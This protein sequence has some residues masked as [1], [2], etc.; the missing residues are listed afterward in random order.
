MNARGW[1]L[2]AALAAPPLWAQP[3]CGPNERLMSWP[4]ENPVWQFCWL[5]PAQSSGTNGSGLEIRNVHYNGRL[6]LKRGHVP[7][8]NVQYGPTGPCGGANDCYRD[9]MDLEQSYLSDNVC[10]PPNG[11]NCG[12][13]EPACPPITVCEEPGGVDVCGDPPLDCTRTCFTG[14]SAEKQADRLI[15]TSQ[16]RA[17]WYRYTMKWTFFD[18][19]RIQPFFGFSAVTDNC[20]NYAHTHHAY[21]RLD[22]DI[23]GPASDLVTEGPNPQP[24]PPGRGRRPPLVVLRS[25]AMRVNRDPQLT[26][27]FIDAAT[28]RGYRIV[29]G[30]EAELRAD[31]F[32]I[33]D[34]WL[35]NYRDTEI[36]DTGQSGPAC[37]VKIG[38]YLNGESLSDDVV[39]WYRT[40]AHHE[41]AHLDE[42]H[43]VGPMLVPIGDWSP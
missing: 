9:W 28:K 19:G 8:I 10:P 29:P 27:S 30:A 23:D 17:G 2:A 13:A 25:E 33:G 22:F 16:C 43:S 12:Y 36:D 7:I 3:V 34:L 20:V 41:A 18:D 40:G 42:C 5:R 35:L 1:L 38:N 21:W 32:S 31:T 15:M 37:V 4:D 6:V 26:W 11:A 39:A 14:V 24:G